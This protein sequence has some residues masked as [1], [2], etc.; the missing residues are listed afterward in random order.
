MN[1]MAAGQ[2]TQKGI[3]QLVAYLNL[4]KGSFPANEDEG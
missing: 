1:V 2:V 3:E 4:I